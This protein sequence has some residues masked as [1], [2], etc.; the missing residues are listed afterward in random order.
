MT[1]AE[2]KARRERLNLSQA[3]LA[4]ALKVRQHHI[5]RWEGGK[6][7]ITHMRAAWLGAEFSRLEKQSDQ[8]SG[9]DNA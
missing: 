6:V 4:E 5:S 9:R 1:P 8:S 3:A 7:A 2:L